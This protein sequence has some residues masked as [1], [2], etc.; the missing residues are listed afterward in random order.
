MGLHLQ[1]VGETDMDM[2]CLWWEYQ[3]LLYILS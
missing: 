2:V 1:H 3:T